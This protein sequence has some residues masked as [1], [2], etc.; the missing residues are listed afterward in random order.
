M[1]ITLVGPT[2]CGKTSLSIK[3]AK[4]VPHE[5]RNL[6]GE[7]YS[8][9]EIISCDAM[10]LYRGMDIGTAKIT[11]DEMQSV[12]H[13]MI[14]CLDIA[15]E[16]SV[17]EYK[18]ATRQII[19]DIQARAGLPIVVGG[20]GLYMR[21]VTDKL[22]FPPTDLVV[23]AKYEQMAQVHGNAFLYAMLKEKDE[24]A[25]KHI[26]PNNIRRVVRALEAIEVSGKPF[27]STLPTYTYEIP[28]VQFGI[29]IS[30]ELLDERIRLRCEQMFEQGLIE[31]TQ[32]LL[33]QGLRQAKT[34]SKA[35]GY[36]QTIAYIDGEISLAEAVEQTFIAT[37]Q[38]SRRQIKWFRRD[39]RIHW[40]DME[41]LSPT[42]AIEE[43]KQVYKEKLAD[44]KSN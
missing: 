35:T 4:E 38:L 6:N 15:Q 36:A 30:N 32:L 12:P 13:H 22:D 29:K 19:D 16:A 42:Q 33:T 39:K 31:E 9:A 3:M 20:S 7:S 41:T 17:A 26:E 8:F 37:R 1:I 18:Q 24:L 28:T 23:R 25:A 14:D 11:K 2:A 34:A 21:A 5:I 10:Q 27:S 43:I 44:Y 40:L